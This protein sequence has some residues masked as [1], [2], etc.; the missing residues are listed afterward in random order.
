MMRLEPV[1]FCTQNKAKLH[2]IPFN[3]STGVIVENTYPVFHMVISS[4]EIKCLLPFLL[5]SL[6]CLYTH[7]H[8]AATTNQYL[9]I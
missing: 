7:H 6:F 9:L 1:T 4:I 3:W 5:F 2:C 8:P